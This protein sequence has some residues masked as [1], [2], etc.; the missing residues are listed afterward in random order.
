MEP[1]APF[2]HI[3]TRIAPSVYKQAGFNSLPPLGRKRSSAQAQCLAAPASG[4]GGV[5]EDQTS[6]LVEANREWFVW[7][8]VEGF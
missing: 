7:R 3:P 1:S 6:R 5:S 2:G 4:S 8:F